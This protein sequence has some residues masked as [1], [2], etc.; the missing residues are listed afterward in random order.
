MIKISN[1]KDERKKIREIKKLTDR[2]KFNAMREY[3]DSGSY[4]KCTKRYSEFEMKKS[5]WS[6]NQRT[7]RR[8]KKNKRKNKK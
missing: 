7:K 5:V 4:E 3:K 6:D 1:L 8:K 2:I